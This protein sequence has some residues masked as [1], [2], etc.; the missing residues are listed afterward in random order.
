MIS[1]IDERHARQRMVKFLAES[2][3]AKPGSQHDNV[4]PF[5]LRHGRSVSQN[6]LGASSDQAQRGRLRPI[7]PSV[8]RLAGGYGCG[9]TTEQIIGLILALL[10]MSAGLAG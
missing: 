6:T 9:M 5:A 2:Q 3:A 4:R 10:V 1:A 8:S 7:I